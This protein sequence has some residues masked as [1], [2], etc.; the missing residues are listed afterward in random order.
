VA[1][2][3]LFPVGHPHPPP[4][5]AVYF[6]D[7]E[8]LFGYAEVA[9]PAP[10]V[11]CQFVQSVLHGDEPAPSGVLPDPTSEFLVCL[12][13]PEDFGSLEGEAEKGDVAGS[14]H[15]TFVFVDRELEFVRQIVPYAL[16]RP[17]G[18]C[19]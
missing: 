14:R 11:G 8:V 15:L 4:N 12:V 10:E 13:R 3:P 18:G 17:G 6:R 7:F 16:H 2:P 9:H 5:P 19:P 1:P